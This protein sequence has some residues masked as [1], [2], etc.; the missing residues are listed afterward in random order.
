MW[1]RHRGGA[2][3]NPPRP[4]SA[5]LPGAPDPR[6]R[7]RAVRRP[8]PGT[9]ASLLRIVCWGLVA[10]G[11]TI[12]LALVLRASPEVDDYGAI[13][14]LRFLVLAFVTFV[15]VSPSL[16]AALA[17]LAVASIPATILHELG[18]GVIARRLLGG[19]VQ[20]TVGTAGRIADVRLGQ[21]A[22]SVNALGHPARGAGYASFSASRASARDV[23]M[24]A[25]AGPAASLVGCA[26]TGWALFASPSTGIVHNLLWG[27]TAA[28]A[29]CV[30]NI[31]P[32]EFQEHRG[33]PRL[34][35]DGLVALRAARI[36]RLRR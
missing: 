9:P 11:L 13:E 29:F 23:V 19:E 26:L 1:E 18:H 20:I 25:L 3:P 6:G 35:S 5:S 2:P 21:I 27:A 33:G 10:I 7:P 31:V 34:R 24:I 12:G 32:F 17:C 22:M 4:R 14:P 28:G 15:R 30:L 36:A 8:E 16:P